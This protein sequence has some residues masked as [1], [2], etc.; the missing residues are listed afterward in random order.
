MPDGLEAR[1]R[2]LFGGVAVV[3]VATGAFALL[4]T[5]TTEP[6]QVTQPQ[7]PQAVTT[8]LVA[9]L[10]AA[11]VTAFATLGARVAWAPRRSTHLMPVF[12]VA[13]LAAF[14][15]E[16]LAAV[17]AWRAA[18]SWTEAASVAAA[19]LVLALASTLGWLALWLA[20]RPGDATAKRDAALFDA[21]LGTLI[22][23]GEGLELDARDADV[24]ARIVA[25]FA[26][27]STRRRP[28]LRLALRT[29][30]ALALVKYRSRFATADQALRERIVAGLATSRYP[31]LRALGGALDEIVVGAF[32][33][34]E[35]VR[36]AAGD[37]LLRLRS[38]LESGPNAEAHR[39]RRAAAEQAAAAA[40]L[41]AADD[42]DA[43]DAASAGP[44]TGAGTNATDG[45]H[46]VV[47]HRD[48]A[49]APP[50]AVPG[51]DGDRSRDA[52]PATA[53]HPATPASAPVAAPVVAQPASDGPK[54]IA[55][56][57]DDLP[58]DRPWTLGVPAQEATPRPAMGPVLRVART[59]GPTRR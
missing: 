13:C 39:A 16:T 15:G 53:S 37:D 54:E 14:A 34:D 33:S 24:R 44:A 8:A 38:L 27:R 26:A 55:P 59:G 31:R 51:T 46:T 56:R 25:A 45:E 22:P 42:A 30:D 21:L 28:A 23:E 49:P 18:A 6:A 5:S 9:A 35:R 4:V 3:L 12:A 17:H 57:T 32:W 19:S 10:L 7:L 58:F 36:T 29:L 47:A 41:I 52:Q 2:W 50:A 48:A 11:A 43:A 20:E 40:L 1:L